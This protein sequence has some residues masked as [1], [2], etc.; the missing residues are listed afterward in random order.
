MYIVYRVL[1]LSNGSLYLA[2]LNEVFDAG[3]MVLNTSKMKGCPSIVVAHVHVDASQIGSLK[4]HLVSL[5][6]RLK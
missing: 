4:R 2:R 3:G 5:D 1:E 6:R